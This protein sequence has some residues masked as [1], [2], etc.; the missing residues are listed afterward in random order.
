M[1]AGPVGR[2]RR[3]VL[4]MSAYGVPE[5][6]IAAALAIDEAR[7]VEFFTDELQ[8]GAVLIKAN[9]ITALFDSARGRNGRRPSVAAINM[10]LKRV[11]SA[12]RDERRRT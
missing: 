9:M 3:A 12:E 5:A 4:T 7:L 1:P 2:Q 10:I 6:E 11:E 8:T